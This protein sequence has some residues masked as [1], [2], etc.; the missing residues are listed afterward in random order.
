MSDDKFTMS[1]P[2]AYRGPTRYAFWL[3]TTE[4]SLVTFTEH[5]K[6]VKAVSTSDDDPVRV[7]V[8]IDDSFDADEAWHWIRT[9]LEHEANYIRLDS[10][11]EDAMK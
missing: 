2:K 7:L 10:I 11:W 1:E 9:E 6:C 3:T 8:H 5:L 4:R